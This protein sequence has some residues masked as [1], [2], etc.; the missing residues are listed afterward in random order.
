MIQSTV[1]ITFCKQPLVYMTSLQITSLT[2]QLKQMTISNEELRE[3]VGVL[4][5]E[6]FQP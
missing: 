5:V 6:N 3:A 2:T 1:F 4:K